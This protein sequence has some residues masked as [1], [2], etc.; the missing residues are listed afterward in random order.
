MTNQFL[1]AFRLVF[2]IRTSCMRD[3]NSASFYFVLPKPTCPSHN[4]VNLVVLTHTKTYKMSDDK[5]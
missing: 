4:K 2:G 5:A 1:T 3:S